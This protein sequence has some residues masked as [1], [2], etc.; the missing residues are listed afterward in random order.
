M[1]FAMLPVL[2]LVLG[3]VIGLVATGAAASQTGTEDARVGTIWPYSETMQ[4]DTALLNDVPAKT[5]SECWTWALGGVGLG[6]LAAL[7][8]LVLRASSPRLAVQCIR[9]G[10]TF[11]VLSVG[12][13]GSFGTASVAVRSYDEANSWLLF[14]AILL[15]AAIGAI[16][17]LALCLK[18]MPYAPPL[19]AACGHT[20][21]E[22]QSPCS[23]CG[24]TVDAWRPLFDGR[25]WFL[26]D[27]AVMALILLGSFSNLSRL[28]PG[29]RP[30]TAKV[31]LVSYSTSAPPVPFA[32]P[33]A[34][35]DAEARNRAQLPS[36]FELRATVAML[37]E[38]YWHTW[39]DKAS[40]VP[41]ERFDAALQ[42]DPRFARRNAP[43]AVGRIRSERIDGVIQPSR[44]EFDA[45][46][47]RAA[48]TI[49]AALDPVS[50][51]DPEAVRTIVVDF[52]ATMR[53]RL[54]SGSAKTTV[55]DSE[56]KLPGVFMS[57]VLVGMPPPWWFV[58]ALVAGSCCPFV[59]AIRRSRAS[60]EVA[61]RGFEKKYFA[62]YRSSAG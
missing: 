30:T 4:L 8:G 55:D 57:T 16:A 24:T 40:L 22:L 5:L 38:P 17:F 43:E 34:D 15:Y 51:I 33:S 42:I 3:L 46:V 54:E 9:W 12:V 6:A 37:V 53:D 14:A 56:R 47:A 52:A 10:A 25:A 23:E 60:I 7:L 1:L 36:E 28:V 32:A 18:P 39:A 58:M 21:D 13:A 49:A 61:E 29:D 45:D 41:V 59:F 26:L 11:A 19:C 31:T 20:R 62:W 2:G 35:M 44:A 50:G 48:D 27:A